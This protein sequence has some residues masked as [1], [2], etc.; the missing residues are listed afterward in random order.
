MHAEAAEPLRLY[1]HDNQSLRQIIY[2][3]CAHIE[4]TRMTLACEGDIGSF[5]LSHAAG[6]AMRLIESND[7]SGLLLSFTVG[8]V[9]LVA[10]V[11]SLIVAPNLV[12]GGWSVEFP[13]HDFGP[14][15]ALIAQQPE[16][17][18]A[19]SVAGESFDL[20]PSAEDRATLQSLAEECA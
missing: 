20:T 18:I 6:L 10:E 2:A 9:A 7:R 3:D 11:T 13:S 15:F 4:C 12:A 8:R 5:G 17:N 1:P 14:V 16:A 19:V